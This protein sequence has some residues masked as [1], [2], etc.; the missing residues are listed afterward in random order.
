MYSTG[1]MKKE[2][3]VCECTPDVVR[4]VRQGYMG[5]QPVLPRTAFSLRL[6]RYHHI[7][8]KHCSVGLAPFVTAQD[9]YLDAQNTLLLVSGSDKVS[10][11]H[12]TFYSI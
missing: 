3:N 4:L 10:S 9:E 12:A 8:W 2:L 11:P 6:L 7:L 1:R 5:G